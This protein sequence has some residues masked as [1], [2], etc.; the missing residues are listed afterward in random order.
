MTQEIKELNVLQASDS[1]FIVRS[2]EPGQM[3][4]IRTYRE[5]PDLIKGLEQE[6]FS[7][8]STAVPAPTQAQ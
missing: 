6:F 7:I 5:F 1:T 3:P 2:S 8:P 4:V